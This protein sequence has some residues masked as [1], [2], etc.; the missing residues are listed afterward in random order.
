MTA[1]ARF[2]ICI[3]CS[4]LIFAVIVLFQNRSVHDERQNSTIEEEYH[5]EAPRDWRQNINEEYRLRAEQIVASMDRST[6]AAQVLLTS[7]DGMDRVHESIKQLLVNVPPG[8]IILYSFNMSFTMDLTCNFIE[9][10]THCIAD[11]S[12]PPFIAA[13]QEGGRVMRF[14]EEIILPAPLSYW[15]QLVETNKAV[16]PKIIRNG[17]F[18]AVMEAAFSVI[19]NDAAVAGRDLRNI[20]VTWNLA[21]VAETLTAQN[22]PVLVDRSYGPYP[23]FVS[24]AA[25]AFVR[26]M[27]GA[28]VAGTLKHFPGNSAEDPHL[29]QAV[30]DVSE[31]ELEM[32]LETFAET[33]HR[34]NP[35]AV[36]LSH[37]II[38]VW[39]T[40]PSSLSPHA[41]KR[42]R[43]MGFAGIITA[44]DYSM[45]AIDTPVEVCAVEALTAGVD[46]IMVWPRNL[47][48]TH[49]EILKAIDTGSLS[50]E[51][52]REAAERIVY[53]KI[54]YGLIR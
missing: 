7:V 37:V 44:D 43:D 36:M 28:G 20:G 2:A 35:A 31:K 42:L 53:Q 15:E 32:N 40:K 49:R 47:I 17:E 1:K 48:K 27:H 9:E 5:R 21:P 3:F 33:I 54:R 34:E 45:T 4:L 38:P 26:G 11:V 46:M 22:R 29:G 6:L 18:P 23:A 14:R 52:V 39:D 24:G 30:L 8:G 41:V 25:S 51:R 50:E 12:V 10:L 13:D 16:L 19:E